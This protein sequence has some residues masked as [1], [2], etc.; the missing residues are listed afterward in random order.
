M[1]RKLVL[2]ITAAVLSLTISGCGNSEKTS[3]SLSSEIKESQI[4]QSSISESV[5]ESTDSNEQRKAEVQ[6][7]ISEP[8]Q[9]KFDIEYVRKQIN[10]KGQPFEIPMALKDLKDGW[11]WKEHENSH[12][13][14]DGS[15]LAYIYYNGKEMFVAGLENYFDGAKDNGIIYNLT[16][17]TDDCSIDSLIPFKSTKQDVIDR[18]GKP[19]EIKGHGSYCY[20]TANNDDKFAGR[21]NEQRIDI[22]FDENETIRKISLTYADLTKE[23]Y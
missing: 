18:Y 16:I 17:E 4:T 8:E 15:G 1:K 22:S 7:E 2:F 13:S 11:T 20:G 19:V 9:G 14:A 6:S 12:Y 21:I 10:I 23:K 5:S 3:A